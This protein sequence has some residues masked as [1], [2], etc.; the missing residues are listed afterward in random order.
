M[1]LQVIARPSRG[2][3]RVQYLAAIIIVLF[4]TDSSLQ[5]DLQYNRLLFKVLRKFLRFYRVGT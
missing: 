5:I 2:Q 1:K 3:T 4:S